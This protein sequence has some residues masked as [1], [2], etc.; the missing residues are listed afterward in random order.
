MPRL[1]FDIETIGEDWNA[2][3]DTTQHVLSRWIK[4]EH[5]E[6]EDYEAAL[7]DIKNGLG[8]S[9]LTG[10]IVA[11]GV[12]DVDKNQ[13]VVYFQAPEAGLSEIQEGNFILKPMTEKQML[14]AFWQGAAKYTEL[15]SYNGRSF[16]A[17]FLAIRS[18]VHGIRPTRNLLEG[19]YPYQQ[20][21]CRHTDLQDELTFYGAVQRKGG[22][23]M[24]ARAFGI[25]SPKADGVTGDDVAALFK[26]K[27]F[28][29]IAKYNTGDLVATAELH[30]VWEKFIRL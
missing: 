28:L 14:E 4:K 21:N 27:R 6:G 30:K 9:P 17:P 18:A 8:F 23:H 13:G 2:M 11:I 1:V 20:K 10:E 12:M 7:E 29:D 5:G 15:I 3:D 22:L 19:R 25:K 26:E 24:Y 16:D